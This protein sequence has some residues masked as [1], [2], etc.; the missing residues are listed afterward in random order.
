MLI[1]RKIRVS[2]YVK[3][4]NLQQIYKCVLK[5]VWGHHPDRLLIRCIAAPGKLLS[6]LGTLDLVISK[7]IFFSL[8]KKGKTWM[9]WSYYDPNRLLNNTKRY[10]MAM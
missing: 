10:K 3:Y 4:K 5:C 9:Q 7:N 2:N 1:S 8:A 6:L